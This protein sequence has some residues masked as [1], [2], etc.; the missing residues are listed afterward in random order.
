M[1]CLRCIL[2]RW[3]KRRIARWQHKH[4]RGPWRSRDWNMD[5]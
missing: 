3:A 1:T 4:R 5:P 2:P